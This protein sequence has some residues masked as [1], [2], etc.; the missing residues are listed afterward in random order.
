MIQMK[1]IIFV[2][3]SVIGL[4][5]ICSGQSLPVK[6]EEL[7]SPDFVKAIEQ[8]GGTCLLPFGV[9]EKHGP[10]LPLNVDTITPALWL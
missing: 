9:V 4:S 3:A 2:I 7:T 5:Y 8:A 10:H 1:Q 6:W